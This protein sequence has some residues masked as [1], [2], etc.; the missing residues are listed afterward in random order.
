MKILLLALLSFNILA[1]DIEF[2]VPQDIASEF[3][4]R[5][6]SLVTQTNEVLAAY[7]LMTELVE[8]VLNVNPEL[9]EEF[10]ILTFDEFYEEMRDIVESQVMRLELEAEDMS[11]FTRGDC[12]EQSYDKEFQAYDIHERL[13]LLENRLAHFNETGEVLVSEEY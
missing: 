5:C 3:E 9:V 7:E 10:E 2:F 13:I 11:N 12:V 8:E 4:G 1:Q 6:E